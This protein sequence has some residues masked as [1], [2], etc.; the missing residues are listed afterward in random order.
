MPRRGKGREQDYDKVKAALKRYYRLG[1]LSKAIRDS[2]SHGKL[3]QVRESIFNKEIKNRMR[4]LC[5]R[6]LE[7]NPICFYLHYVIGKVVGVDLAR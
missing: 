2:R 4:N 6:S 3:Q 1:E 7:S 5:G